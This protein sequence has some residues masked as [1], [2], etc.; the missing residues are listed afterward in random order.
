VEKHVV[1]RKTLSQYYS[2]IKYL[3]IQHQQALAYVNSVRDQLAVETKLSLE[4]QFSGPL[5][6]NPV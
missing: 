1:D 4:L 6:Q 5:Q 3:H 2:N